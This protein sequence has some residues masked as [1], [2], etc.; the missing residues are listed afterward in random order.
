MRD[1]RQRQAIRTVFDNIDRPLGPKE[2]LIEASRDVP[3]LG[4]ATV[5]RNIK[6][7]VDQGELV[8]V[9][10]PGQPSRYSLPRHRKE[11]LFLCEKSDRA[12]FI[13]REAVHFDVT[14][15]SEDF[16]VNGH[17]VVLYGEYR[18][19]GNFSHTAA[20]FALRVS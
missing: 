4:I 8:T 14:N 20:P 3:N 19:A 13:D 2:V 10:L 12:F 18:E 16:T 1:T 6:T 7:M 9:E 11:Y 5:Y 15:L 17:A